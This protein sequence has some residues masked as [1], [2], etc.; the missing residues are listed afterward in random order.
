MASCPF[1]AVRERKKLLTGC[2]LD[3]WPDTA[4]QATDHS[5]NGRHGTYV[6]SPTVEPA[7]GRR[8]TYK[9][10]AAST[11]YI[12]LSS[13][14]A[15][16]SSLEDWT[17]IIRYQLATTAEQTLFSIHDATGV[18]C[19]QIKSRGA[20]SQYAQVRCRRLNTTIL[21]MQT[22]F[23][24]GPPLVGSYQMYPFDGRM[25]DIVVSRSVADGI[26]FYID[27]IQ[28]SPIH[29]TGNAAVDIGFDNLSNLNTLTISRGNFAG[30]TTYS[31]ANVA[32][33]QIFDHQLSSE[34]L[35]L[36]RYLGM[37]VVG[38]GQSNWTGFGNDDGNVV[39]KASHPEIHDM[40]NEGT[41]NNYRWEVLT[42]PINASGADP[43]SVSMALP[44]AKRMLPFAK[45]VDAFG[46]VYM[47]TVAA[48][49]T[50][51]PDNKWNSGDPSYNNAKVRIN[52]AIRQGCVVAFVVWQ[53]GENDSY[54]ET[55]ANAQ[56]AAFR[57]FHT[58]LCS[59]IDSDQLGTLDQKVWLL[60]SMTQGHI[61][62]DV[63]P[64]I[65]NTNTQLLATEYPNMAFTS[66]VGLASSN[67]HYS[68]GDTRK[69]ARRHWENFR[70]MTQLDVPPTTVS[71]PSASRGLTIEV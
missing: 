56:P 26:K 19:L 37:M 32:R 66:S 3:I 12:N 53:G 69:M 13:H 31:N 49:G 6:N 61:A 41:S 25:H 39:L 42:E 45:E 8:R 59:D 29:N 14:V 20:G 15:A 67:I 33:L 47:P 27:G 21:D 43:N 57:A 40:M 4:E 18:N 54:N 30:T 50:G 2:V 11:N 52:Y 36:A 17:I 9:F 7:E 55:N 64:G 28:V 22:G 62:S 51:F 48:P 70:A 65:V 63:A 68:A 23:T 44:L 5:G 24:N 60:G 10:T 58:A 35:H 1:I 46:E 16:M 71:L 34:E 38:M